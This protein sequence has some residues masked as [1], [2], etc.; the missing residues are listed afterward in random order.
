M[1]LKLLFYF[2][3]YSII[4]SIIKIIPLVYS[5]GISRLLNF[6]I[7]KRIK[8][9]WII[10]TGATDGIG[11]ELAKNLA[12]RK[13]NLIILGRNVNKL[14]EM[15]EEIKKEGVECRTVLVDFTRESD[16]EFLKEKLDIGML[17]N[18]VGCSSDHPKFLIE[19]DKIRDI[20][21]INIKNTYILTKKVLTKMMEVNN[22]VVL[23]IG[24]FTGDFPSPLLSVY[25][26]SKAMIK[27]WS[28]SLHYEMKPYKIHVEC[29][30]TGYVATKMSKIKT[31]SFFVP[32][33]K[34]YADNILRT[35]GTMSVSI[36]YFP[37]VLCYIGIIL[38][39]DF[40]MGIGVFFTLF[41]TRKKAIGKERKCE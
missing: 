40:V 16:F 33:P 4:F 25:S 10:I 18:N 3:K 7:W 32:T 17:I 23:N 36:P 31:P 30:N 1:I 9:K 8:G 19:E 41:R 21:N 37:H 28:K 24:S 12:R 15:E 6:R 5:Y 39:P 38:I 26:S 20:V 11:K 2:I 35:F 22:G 34:T 29:M 14:E 27:A 13:F